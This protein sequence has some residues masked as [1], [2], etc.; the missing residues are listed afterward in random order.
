MDEMA[1]MMHAHSITGQNRL[2][3]RY[4]AGVLFMYL[5][6]PGKEGS[7]SSAGGRQALRIS[8]D[9]STNK[10]KYVS[11]VISKIFPDSLYREKEKT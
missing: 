9:S 10:K 8:L 4:G 11:L 7:Y 6:L 1:I 3:K 5:H 2:R